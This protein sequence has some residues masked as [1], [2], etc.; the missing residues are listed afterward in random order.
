MRSA[1]SS[2]IAGELGAS[3]SVR[4][5]T[6]QDTDLRDDGA[7]AIA[8]CL[9]VLQ[10]TAAVS[11]APH[12]MLHAALSHFVCCTL[13]VVCVS[14]HAFAQHSTTIEEVHLERNRIGAAGGTALGRAMTINRSVRAVWDTEPGGIA[15]RVG[16]RAVRETVPCGMPCRAGCR[17]VRDAVPVGILC[18]A[19]YRA[20]RDAV[21]VGILCRA[22]YHAGVSAPARM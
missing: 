16:C 22:G 2:R 5:L 9:Q 8:E 11:Y 6:I 14:A 7:T 19:G 13:R 18:R 4:I 10:R 3:A 15:C 20:V 21:P 1:V 12:C 17:A